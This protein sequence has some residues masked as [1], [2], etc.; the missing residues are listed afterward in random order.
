MCRA[1]LTMCMLY[2]V[3]CGPLDLDP[4]IFGPTWDLRKPIAVK[5]E[6]KQLQNGATSFPAPELFTAAMERS[7]SQ[8]GGIVTKDLTTQQVIT[9][10]DTD[11]DKCSGASV[12]AYSEIRPVTRRVAICHSITVLNDYYNRDID[13]VTAIMFHELGHMLGNKGWHI[14]GDAV[15]N[16][17]CPTRYVMAWNARCHINV[18]DYVGDDLSYVCDGASTVGGVC[19]Q[20]AR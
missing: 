2:L 4:H 6:N 12:F 11:G 14:G 17:E 9:L 5:V 15:P 10:F 3:A 19:M 16:G 8:A 20:K 18:N 7:I 1:I 13:F